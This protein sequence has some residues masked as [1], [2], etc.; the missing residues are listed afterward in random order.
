VVRR[1]PH[2]CGRG[3]MGHA[4]HARGED[5]IREVTAATPAP[6]VNVSKDRSQNPLGPPKPFHRAIDTRASNPAWSAASATRFTSSQSRICGGPSASVS[7]AVPPERFDAKTPTFRRFGPEMR[8]VAL[9]GTDRS[10][11][12]A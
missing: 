1:R 9:R 11:F 2:F 5:W 7:A 4:Q 10:A 12:V 6:H 8:R 3:R